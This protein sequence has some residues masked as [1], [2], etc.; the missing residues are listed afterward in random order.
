MARRR[1]SALAPVLVLSLTGCGTMG[2]YVHTVPV[3]EGDP[4]G[5]Y[6]YSGVR[7]DVEAIRQDIADARKNDSGAERVGACM[8]VAFWCIDLPLSAVADTLM[9]PVLAYESAG[10]AKAGGAQGGARGVPP[11]SSPDPP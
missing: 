10:R 1:A 3:G 6:A 4:L 9:L 5:F 11:A 7:E 8:E 2:S